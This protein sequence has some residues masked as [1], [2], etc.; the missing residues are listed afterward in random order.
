MP[1]F[2]HIAFNFEGRSSS[3]RDDA[4][5]K[6]MDTG[7]DWYKYAPNCWLIWTNRTPKKWY[8]ILKP[9]IH[10]DDSIF[11]TEIEMS[12]SFGYLPRV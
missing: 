5:K 9:K 12:N 6:A 7:I 11:I 2:L 3:S 4:I 1:K 8:D 10:A